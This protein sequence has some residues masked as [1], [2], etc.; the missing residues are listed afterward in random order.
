MKENRISSFNIRT[1]LIVAKIP[2]GKVMSYGQ[3]ASAVGSPRA[4]RAVGTAMRFAPEYMDLPC[5]R[6]VNKAGEMAPDYAF[7]G[8]ETQRSKLEEEGVLFNMDGKVDMEKSLWRTN[9]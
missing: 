6:V 9:E 3:I 2:E 4:F 1:Y 8:A 7:G 5:H